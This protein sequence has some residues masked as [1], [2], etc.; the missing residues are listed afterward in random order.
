MHLEFYSFIYKKE[1]NLYIN[2]VI[3][4]CIL[5][6]EGR[7]MKYYFILCFLLINT[8]TA[9]EKHYLDQLHSNISSKVENISIGTDGYLA[10]FISYI[11][12]SFKK[13]NATDNLHPESVDELF[14]NEKYINETKKS[15]LRLSSEYSYNTLEN[16]E[17][18]IAI[19]GKVALNKS[20]LR[21]KLFFQGITN[22]YNSK[23]DTL[24]E[25]IE[26]TNIGISYLDTLK[27]NL[28][29]QYS[30]GL[31]NINPYANARIAYK[32]KLLDWIIAPEQSFEYSLKNH[33]SENTSIYFDKNLI[34]KILLRLRAERSTNSDTD[35]M[36]YLSSI[37]FFWTPQDKTG[38]HLSQ[39]FAGN[40]KY[41]TKNNENF[42]GI[43]NYETKVTFR[44]NILRKWFFYEISSSVNFAKANDFQANYRLYVRVDI[45]FGKDY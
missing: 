20:N 15:F 5:F 43:Y 12:T 36:S 9:D 7:K 31:K 29:V 4:Y 37:C 18:N 11:T 2:T 10:D 40:T 24:Q 27:K 22:R 17:L 42:N 8:L 19:R 21:T 34:K 30:I 6:K 25:K 1:E 44:Q 45:F 16:N 38:I 32:Y 33:F 14:Q 26:S 23:L 13:E 39:N 28:D 35:G 41:I 3:I